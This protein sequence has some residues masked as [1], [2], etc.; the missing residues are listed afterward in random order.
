MVWLASIMTLIGAADKVGGI[1]SAITSFKIKAALIL[2]SAVFLFGAGFKVASWKYEAGEVK[3]LKADISTYKAKIKV[4]NKQMQDNA[5][6]HQ[7]LSTQYAVLK[8]RSEKIKLPTCSA[9]AD[10]VRLWNDAKR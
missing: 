4:F 10:A 6:A 9:G 2:I 3:S 7:V 1:V 5:T 8:E